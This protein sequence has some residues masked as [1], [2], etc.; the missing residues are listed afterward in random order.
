MTESHS[1]LWSLTHGERVRYAGTVAALGCASLFLFAA[2]QLAKSAL[3]V[4]VSRDLSLVPGWLV[5]PAQ[6]LGWEIT[7]S[8]TDFLIASGVLIVSS[9]A[10]SGMCLYWN[11]RLAARASEATS[12]WKQSIAEG[13]HKQDLEKAKQQEKPKL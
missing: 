3:D 1:S 12:K 2:P 7:R 13:Q 8:L 10:L 5:A 4:I 9:A 11:G 6:V